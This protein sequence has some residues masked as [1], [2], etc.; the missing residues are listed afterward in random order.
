[1]SARVDLLEN[2]LFPPKFTTLVAGSRWLSGDID[3]LETEKEQT[4]S[5]INSLT[6]DL[7]YDFN[8]NGIIDTPGDVIAANEYYDDSKIYV[9]KIA[10]DIPNEE[11]TIKTIKYAL[12]VF[13]KTSDEVHNIIKEYMSQGFD[14]MR[15]TTISE[16]KWIWI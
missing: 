7:N 8:R 10:E 16:T 6:E 5:I 4:I 11:G 1:M 9:V 12:P 14:N 2:K 3:E 15:L 13:A